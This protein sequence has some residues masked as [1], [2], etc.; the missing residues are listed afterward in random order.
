MNLK[1]YYVVHKFPTLLLI[2]IQ[3][4]LAHNFPPS[5]TNIHSNIFF[6]SPLMSFE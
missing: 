4:N 5:F 3:M 6:P 2:L 1:F